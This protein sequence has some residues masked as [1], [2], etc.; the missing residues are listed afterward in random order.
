MDKHKYFRFGEWEFKAQDIDVEKMDDPLDVACP[1][2]VRKMWD[3]ECEVIQW[4]VAWDCYVVLVSCQFCGNRVAIRYH[5]PI[6]DFL[7]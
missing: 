4:G 3:I 6:E 1:R 2:C 7:S 5:Q